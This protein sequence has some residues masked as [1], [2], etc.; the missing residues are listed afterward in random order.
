MSPRDHLKELDSSQIPLSL[1]SYLDSLT[2]PSPLDFPSTGAMFS[3]SSDDLGDASTSAASSRPDLESTTAILHGTHHSFMGGS[4]HSKPTNTV[5]PEDGGSDTVLINAYSQLA[6]ILFKI[7]NFQTK[8]ETKS[9]STH[10]PLKLQQK[11]FPVVSSL[12][13]ILKDPRLK[14]VTLP[15]TEDES[16]SSYLLLGTS[17]IS[18]AVEVY[19]AQIGRFKTTVEPHK[20]VDLSTGERLGLVTDATSMDFHL[21]MLQAVLMNMPESCLHDRRTTELLAESRMVFRAC[22]ERYGAS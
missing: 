20:V 21:A 8:A 19:H 10:Q 5:L 17:V 9:N 4:L 11:L 6:N 2:I 16:A 7:R 15:A 1:P 14:D 18:I 13:D 3:Q 22:I 12:C